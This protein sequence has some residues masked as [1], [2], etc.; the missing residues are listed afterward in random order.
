MCLISKLSLIFF[1][2]YTVDEACSSGLQPTP[3]LL[4]KSADS[5]LNIFVTHDLSEDDWAK[6]LLTANKYNI[7]CRLHVLS[8]SCLL[9]KAFFQDN[10]K[11]CYLQEF[12]LPATVYLAEDVFAATQELIR[13]CQQPLIRTVDAIDSDDVTSAIS[14]TFVDR[15]HLVKDVV[16][17]FL[18]LPT[19]KK[20]FAEK[21]KNYKNDM[22][23][24]AQRLPCDIVEALE[25]GRDVILRGKFTPELS[26]ILMPLIIRYSPA[27]S[28]QA[29][30][31]ILT[32]NAQ[33]FACL[34]SKRIMPTKLLAINDNKVVKTINFDVTSSDL[35]FEFAQT[36]E[37]KRQQLF[38]NARQQSAIVILQGVTGVGKT[39]F[40][41]QF[42]SVFW[43]VEAAKTFKVAAPGGRI[44]F[45]DEFNFADDSIFIDG[46][47][48]WIGANFISLEPGDT[49]VLAI[50]PISYGRERKA[51]HPQLLQKAEVIEFERLPNACLYQHKL[52]P[53]LKFIHLHDDSCELIARILLN[54]YQT[55]VDLSPT[56]ERISA[57]EL[58][59]M[60]LLFVSYYQLDI[61]IKDL[62]NYCALSV[63]AH[64]VNKEEFATLPA[65]ADFARL[66]KHFDP[67]PVQ[68]QV[69]ADYVA[70]PEFSE[71]FVSIQH[72]LKVCRIVD[73]WPNELN[74]YFDLREWNI[75]ALSGIGKT[76][77]MRQQLMAAGLV[78]VTSL[79]Q[80]AS[81]LA[82]MQPLLIE[83]LEK[84]YDK[85]SQFTKEQQ[86]LDYLQTKV[87]EFKTQLKWLKGS[88]FCVISADMPAEQK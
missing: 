83:D 64:L 38:A 55:I 73:A 50:N 56:A 81:S 49:I 40:I 68:A 48:V 19:S 67:K 22:R 26:Q 44:W 52:K 13:H 80:M 66:K 29:K 58:K 20:Q 8:Q 25:Q 23:I 46:N 33:T 65:Y 11:S 21:V 31:Y 84:N 36:Y 37:V 63:A 18:Q 57:R 41:R 72:M 28:S 51:V 39:E 88:R 61:D 10:A 82:N 32:Q 70:V 1:P 5:I 53:I 9:P 14:A 69:Q 43:G 79:A 7:Q 62:A 6:F 4:A 16:Q 34:Q 47:G 35:S 27:Y 86:L 2:A 45:F 24:V 17:A 87:D 76:H 12:V 77:F 42:N 3:G 54:M 78:P 74:A 59:F 15:H 71:A 60:G 30:L 85:L 75:E